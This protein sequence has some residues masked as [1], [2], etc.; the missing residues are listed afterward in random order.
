MTGNLTYGTVIPAR[1]RIECTVKCLENA[2]CCMSS[3]NRDTNA[4]TIDLSGCCDVKTGQADDTYVMIKLSGERPKD[5]SDI[6]VQCNA[7]TSSVYT[8]YPV[9]SCGV[10]VFCMMET[11]GYSWTIGKNVQSYNKVLS[12]V[13]VLKHEQRFRNEMLNQSET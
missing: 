2:D 11:Y 12:S 4:C 6:S 7:C 1:S 8:I 5:C 3:Y 13:T 10:D 9:G